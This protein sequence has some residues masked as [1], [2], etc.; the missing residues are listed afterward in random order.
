MVIVFFVITVVQFI[1]ICTDCL[2]MRYGKNVVEEKLG[3]RCNQKCRDKLKKRQVH[4]LSK[5][6]VTKK[7]GSGT[8]TQTMS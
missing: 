5:E 8:S 1:H 7:G 6:G 4:M 2:Y 3:E